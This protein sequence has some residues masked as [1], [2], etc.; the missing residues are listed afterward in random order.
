MA[1]FGSAV[2]SD[3]SPECARKRTSADHFEFMG[4]R[5]SCGALRSIRRT[6]KNYCLKIPNKPPGCCGGGCGCGGGC[7]WNC[8]CG[9]GDGRCACFGCGGRFCAG[10]GTLGGSGCTLTTVAS[11]ALQS[12][13]QIS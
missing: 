8:G 2:M 10:G 7:C 11:G 13:S 1:L 4:S 9:G 3:L 12:V 6:W 5:R